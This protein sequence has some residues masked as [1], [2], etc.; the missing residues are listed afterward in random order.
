MV[1]QFAPAFLS[2]QSLDSFLDS[3]ESLVLHLNSIDCG[4]LGLLHHGLPIFIQLPCCTILKR[5]PSPAAP[6]VYTRDLPVLSCHSSSVYM[7]PPSTVFEHSI[8]VLLGCNSL[9][10]TW[11]QRE[12]LYDLY[13]YYFHY[14]YGLSIILLC[15][16]YSVRYSFLQNSPLITNAWAKLTMPKGFTD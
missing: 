2:P 15:A 8:W 10:W 12:M 11:K 14:H 13:H 1:E 6:Q 3:M 7:C 4:L 9:S 5:S 16:D